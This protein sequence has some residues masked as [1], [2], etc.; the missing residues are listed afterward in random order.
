MCVLPEEL[1]PPFLAN[2]FNSLLGPSQQGRFLTEQLNKAGTQER[3]TRTFKRISLKL[4][5]TTCGNAA[6]GTEPSKEKHERDGN[7]PSGKRQCG[8]REGSKGRGRE[9]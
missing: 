7:L 4:L 1:V 3:S 6:E 9:G 5:K 2:S 8:R